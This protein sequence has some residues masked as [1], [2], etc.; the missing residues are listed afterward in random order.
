MAAYN[1]ERFILRSV[2]SVLAQTDP[3]FELIVVDDCSRDR[4]T[5]I[6]A[7]IND[8]R[9]LIL[10]NPVNLGVVG[11]RRASSRSPTRAAA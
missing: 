10:R 6:V 11:S 4:T 8:Q 2:Q 1:A 7:E 3:D 5:E 9:V